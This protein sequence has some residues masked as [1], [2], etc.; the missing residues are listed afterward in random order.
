MFGFLT[1]SRFSPSILQSKPFFFVLYCHRFVFLLDD[2]GSL[3]YPF[4]GNQTLEIY[5]NFEGFPLMMPPRVV[6][7]NPW[8][9]IVTSPWLW[10]KTRGSTRV[11]IKIGSTCGTPGRGW[12]RDWQVCLGFLPIP[13]G[14]VFGPAK[15]Q[16]IQFNPSSSGLLKFDGSEIGHP[17]VEV[18]S[19]SHYLQGFLDPRWFSRRISAINN[20]T[21]GGLW[22]CWLQNQS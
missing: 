21:P 19:F 15:L 1:P 5:G 16:W 6:K 13:Q 14:Q 10:K 11:W 22:F 8:K 12:W 7:K 20:S 18:G 17:L 3:N 9:G 2:Q 4:G